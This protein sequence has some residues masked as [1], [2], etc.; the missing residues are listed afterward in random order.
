MPGRSS[1]PRAS[2]LSLLTPEPFLSPFHL[3]GTISASIPRVS[4]LFLLSYFFFSLFLSLFVHNLSPSLLSTGVPL[5]SSEKN[6][7]TMATMHPGPK[8]F[9]K[10]R[11]EKKRR[12]SLLFEQPCVPTQEDLFFECILCP[13]CSFFVCVWPLCPF[14]ATAF[15][16]LSFIL[17]TP[18]PSWTFFYWDFFFFDYFKSRLL[19]RLCIARLRFVLC[20]AKDFFS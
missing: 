1:I 4:S 8:P 2:S 7:C 9:V 16:R 14:C 10:H 3:S 6:K 13:L 5:M 17:E 19:V 15:G 18:N 20:H 12:R 11:G